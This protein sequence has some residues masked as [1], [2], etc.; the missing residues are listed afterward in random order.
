[1]HVT[2]KVVTTKT[3]KPAVAVTE[4]N[5]LLVLREEIAKRRG[6]KGHEIDPDKTLPEL[7]L[8]SHRGLTRSACMTLH[9]APLNG[10]YRKTMTVRQ[11]AKAIMKKQEGAK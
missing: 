6:V 2:S 5:V 9:V 7:R 1:M 8:R 11:M 10:Q 4:E 3:A